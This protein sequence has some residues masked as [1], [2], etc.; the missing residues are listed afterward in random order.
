MIESAISKLES[1][2]M[3]PISLIL[4]AL[5]AGAVA[6]AKDT[7][8]KGVKD[9]YEGLKA[10]I[11]RKFAGNEAAKVVLDEHEKDPETYE[12]PLKKKLIETGIDKDEEILKAAEEI[13]KKEDPQGAIAGK[14]NIH[15]A[16]DIKGI[17][18]DISGG[19]ISQDIK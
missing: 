17:V 15:V 19:T 2:A 18:G 9:A 1:Q 3:E 11:K 12:V 7:A 14:Y 5:A 13:M 4:A 16:G 8:K 10:L 6:A